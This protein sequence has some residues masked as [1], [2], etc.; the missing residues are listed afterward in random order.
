MPIPF[1]HR[2][3]SRTSVQGGV[4]RGSAGRRTTEQV[5]ADAVQLLVDAVDALVVVARLEARCGC[6]IGAV[7]RFHGRPWAP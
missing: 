7:R 4:T 2:R 6:G 5:D 1:L 3:Y